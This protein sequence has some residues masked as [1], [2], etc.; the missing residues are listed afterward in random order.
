LG[1]FVKALNELMTWINET[2]KMLNNIRVPHGDVKAI[3]IELAKH[4]VS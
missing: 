3:E 2:D 4:K 1:E